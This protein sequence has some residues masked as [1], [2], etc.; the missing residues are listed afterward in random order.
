MSKSHSLNAVLFAPTKNLVKTSTCI[1]GF[2]LL[3]IALSACSNQ[4][5]LQEARAAEEVSKRRLEEARKLEE[6]LRQQQSISGLPGQIVL[7]GQGVYQ[8]VEASGKNSYRVHPALNLQS[9]PGVGSSQNNNKTDAVDNKLTPDVRILM[10]DHPHDK[11]IRQWQQDLDL[12]SMATNC[13]A[14]ELAKIIPPGALKDD[15]TLVET[16]D[17]FKHLTEEQGQYFLAADFVVLCN[18]VAGFELRV[19][20][21]TVILSDFSWAAS[22]TQLE[23]VSIMTNDLH[24]LGNSEIWVKGISS[25]NYEPP[26]AGGDIFL[27]VLN[28]IQGNDD[29]LTLITEGGDRIAK[30]NGQR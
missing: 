23:T 20:A 15:F 10:Q 5:H 21:N 2:A 8:K 7:L 14:E 19:L 28:S 26:A 27:A 30:T 4:S 24:L 12:N 1:L 9:K 3:M 6:K 29:S 13:S 11:T 22:T 17:V 25:A 16:P 18:R